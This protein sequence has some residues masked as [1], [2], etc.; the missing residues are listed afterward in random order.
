MNNRSGPVIFTPPKIEAKQVNKRKQQTHT[1]T[2]D[3][4]Q[5]I[6]DA[7]TTDVENVELDKSEKNAEMITEEFSN[8]LDEEMDLELE[9]IS[10]PNEIPINDQ[11]NI[12]SF[13]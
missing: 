11:D 4:K 5:E 12:E 8:M 3:N 9:S 2:S 10:Q 13:L 6:N 1:S 7:Y